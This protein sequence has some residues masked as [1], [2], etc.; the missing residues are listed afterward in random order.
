MM[1]III[2]L[3]FYIKICED[4]ETLISENSHTIQILTYRQSVLLYAVPTGPVSQASV[5]EQLREKGGNEL[6]PYSQTLQNSKERH[7]NYRHRC[8]VLREIY[9]K[10]GRISSVKQTSLYLKSRARPVEKHTSKISQTTPLRSASKL[11]NLHDRDQF[12]RHKFK[13]LIHI[14]YP[15]LKHISINKNPFIIF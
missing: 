7:R 15:Q 3:D 1:M 11:Q 2:Y 6:K 5:S 10:F 13:I 9:Q 12:P 8:H 4:L 14:I